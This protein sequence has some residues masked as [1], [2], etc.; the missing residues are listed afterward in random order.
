MQ[1]GW[2]GLECFGA[3]SILAESGRSTGDFAF[4]QLYLCGFHIFEKI[5]DGYP[6]NVEVK[7]RWL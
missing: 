2:V 4:K 6:E 5:L 3:A 1:G 7:L